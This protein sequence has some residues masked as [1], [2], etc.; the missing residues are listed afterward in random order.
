[1]LD[2]Y[3]TILAKRDRHIASTRR[4]KKEEELGIADAGADYGGVVS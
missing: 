4:S 3:H 1:M 2:L